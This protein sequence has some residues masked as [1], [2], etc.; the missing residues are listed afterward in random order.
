MTTSETISELG[1]S[2]TCYTDIELKPNAP[3]CEPFRFRTHRCCQSSCRC[4]CYHI[5]RLCTA[6][7]PLPVQLPHSPHTSRIEPASQHFQ[8]YSPRTHFFVCQRYRFGSATPVEKEH[9][10][11]HM[12]TYDTTKIL[13]KFPGTHLTGL[14]KPTHHKSRRIITRHLHRNTPVF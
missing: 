4:S 11:M 14:Y 1:R 8:A 13:N 2:H 6:H 10:N 3:V 9:G 12:L 7:R 5:Q